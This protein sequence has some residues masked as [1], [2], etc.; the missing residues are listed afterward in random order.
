[1]LGTNGKVGMDVEIIR[2]RQGGFIHLQQ[3]YITSGE[4]IWIDGQADRL[5]ATTQLWAIRES[6]LKISGLGTSGLQTLRLLPGAGKLRS[7]VTPQVETIS[8]IQGEIAWA[9]SKSPTLGQLN[10]WLMDQEENQLVNITAE[11]QAELKESAS[12]LRFTSNTPIQT[13]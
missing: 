10:Y 5:E 12:Y 13:A 8:A 1:M 4:K 9:C 3:Q 7:T 6:V 2:A 11:K